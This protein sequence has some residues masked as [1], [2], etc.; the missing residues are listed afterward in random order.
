MGFSSIFVVFNLI[1]IDK[2][3]KKI[4]EKKKKKRNKL[5]TKT[6]KKTTKPYSLVDC[7]EHTFVQ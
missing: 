6:E 4:R 7:F 1:F 5:K 3:K 2:Q